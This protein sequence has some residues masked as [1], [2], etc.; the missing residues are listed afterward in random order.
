MQVVVG[1]VFLVVA[2]CVLSLRKQPGY[3]QVASWESFDRTNQTR[4][5]NTFLLTATELYLIIARYGMCSQLNLLEN[6]AALTIQQPESIPLLS[7]N[8]NPVVCY[9]YCWY[10][11]ICWQIL[12]CNPRK[13]VAEC[14]CQHF[15]ADAAEYNMQDS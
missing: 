13:T 3:T 11:A 6:V 5:V 15:I 7:S 10:P 2:V 9:C 4:P 14:L 12:S 1:C 8:Q